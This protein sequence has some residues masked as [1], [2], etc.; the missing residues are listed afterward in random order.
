MDL[1]KYK[2]FDIYGIKTIKLEGDFT[3]DSL[4]DKLI[5]IWI[6]YVECDRKCYRSDY[7]KFTKPSPYH[8]DRLIDVQC[9]VVVN[10][11]KHFIK[12]SF[13][14]LEKLPSDNL[15]GLIP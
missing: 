12:T 9:G 7:C 13:P 2:I 1:S 11:L 8:S 5:K 15:V 3:A 10:S 4:A 14:I 6:P